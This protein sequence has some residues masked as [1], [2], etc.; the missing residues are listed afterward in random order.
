M[1]DVLRRKLGVR[2]ADRAPKGV[3]VAAV[4]RKT[5]PRDADAVLSLDLNVLDVAGGSR[6]KEDVLGEIGPNHLAYL[7]ETEDRARGVVILDPA[8]VAGLVEIQVAGQVSEK[9]T[10]ERPPTKTDAIV[11]GE[12]VDAWLATAEKAMAELS[13]DTSWPMTGFERVEGNLSRREVDL[14]L[15]PVEYRTADITLSLAGGAKT[16]VL[17]VATPRQEES[18]GERISTTAERVRQHLPNLPVE[19]HAILTRISLGMKEVSSLAPDTVLPLPEGCLKNVR[20]ETWD[21]RLIRSATLGQLDG[22]KA[23]R[24]QPV[25]GATV[26]GMLAAP[27]ALAPRLE[28]EASPPEAEP[29]SLP[30]A[31]SENPAL[32]GGEAL[33]DLPDLPDIDDLPDLPKLPDLP[34]GDGLPDLPDLPE[35]PEL[36]DLP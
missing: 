15:E 33:P 28:T 10:L 8:L 5:M 34:A 35:L 3:S 16:G 26:V 4:L 22:N 18:S 23:V 12:M 30:D 11:V 29:L 31:P 27:D 2:S 32:A 6:E 20:L 25:A 13:L 24:L 9:P 14:L 21:E 1:S 7:A 36:P 17:R 19:L